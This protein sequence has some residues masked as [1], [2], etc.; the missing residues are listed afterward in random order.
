MDSIV[1]IVEWWGV[2]CG[3]LPTLPARSSPPSLTKGRIIR[4]ILIKLP[5]L[6]RRGGTRERDGEVSFASFRRL[7][8]TV[9][10]IALDSLTL[11]TTPNSL[12]FGLVGV[13][14]GIKGHDRIFDEFFVDS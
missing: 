9:Y 7:P 4:G 5:S 10:R 13:L 6:S 11:N 1:N 14:S 8:S 2:G 12:R 3:E